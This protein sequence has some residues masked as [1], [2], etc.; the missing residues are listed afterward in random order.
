MYGLPLG[1][2]CNPGIDAIK[3]VL[4]PTAN[5]YIFFVSNNDGTHTFSRTLKEHNAAVDFHQK[6]RK[7]RE[8]KSWRDY[9]RRHSQSPS[10]SP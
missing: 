6:N 9:S 5:D 3:A 1:P 4:S 8:G 7:E 10:K 2:I